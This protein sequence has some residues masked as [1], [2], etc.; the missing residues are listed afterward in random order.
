MSYDI[1]GCVFPIFSYGMIW[2]PNHLRRPVRCWQKLRQRCVVPPPERGEAKSNVEKCVDVPES[3]VTS[4]WFIIKCGH[5]ESC[6]NGGF[7]GNII[8]KWGISNFYARLI[9]GGYCLLCLFTGSS[10]CGLII[11]VPSQWFLP[12]RDHVHFLLWVVMVYH[13]CRDTMKKPP[14]FTKSKYQQSISRCERNPQD[15]HTSELFWIIFL[16]LKI[17]T[18][19]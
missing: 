16:D 3:S 12:W 4:R 6:I 5:G 15:T 14:W 2:I 13:F 18:T 19:R 8:H 1:F 7:N 9:T 11:W 17:V 10:Y